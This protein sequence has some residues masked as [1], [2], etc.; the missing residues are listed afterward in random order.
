MTCAK[1]L[2]RGSNMNST[3]LLCADACGCFLV[4]R[5]VFALKY[6]SPHSHAHM[7]AAR[8]PDMG[9]AAAYIAANDSTLKHTS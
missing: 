7:S 8:S 2:Y 6:T 9:C 3:K 4:K 1:I 5:R